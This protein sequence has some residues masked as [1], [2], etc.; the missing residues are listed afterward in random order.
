[1]A[2]A[3]VPVSE[4][5]QAFQLLYERAPDLR[6]HA[7]LAELARLQPASL[8]A[9][10]RLLLSRMDR[11][12]YHSAF[13]IRLSEAEIEYV[14]VDG[15]RLALDR[16]DIAV[17]GPLLETHEYEPHVRRF[18]DDFLRPGMTFIDVG[19]NVGYFALHAARVVGPSGKV[20]AFEPSSENC[21]LLLLSLRANE[22]DHVEVHPFALS[23]RFGL[24][25]FTTHLGSNGSFAPSSTAAL[26]SASCTIVPTMRLDDLPGVGRVD[27][28]KLDTE[29]AEGLVLGGA[30][31]TLS[32]DRPIVVSEFSTE[33]LS[34]VSGISPRTFLDTF[35]DLGYRLNLIDRSSCSLQPIEDIGAF[36]DG[37]VLGRIEDLAFLS[38]PPG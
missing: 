12:V 16:G 4:A 30:L 3:S 5:V 35:Q 36:L 6:E 19:A 17:G 38:G 15:M 31:E 18:L 37:F 7:V 14:E 26:S 11:Q 2:A 20:I 8:A 33:M 23:D 29:G 25:V 21:R 27:F 24:S 32:R 22:M 1:L 13:S 28:L 10:S 34:R 9:W